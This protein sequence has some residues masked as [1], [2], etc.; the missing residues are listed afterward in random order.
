MLR[1][2]IDRIYNCFEVLTSS[3]YEFL[4]RV[5]GVYIKAQK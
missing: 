1:V 3:E 2:L 5:E 4:L